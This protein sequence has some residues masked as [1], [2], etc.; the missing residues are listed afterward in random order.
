MS[1]Y[2]KQVSNAFISA[3]P[4]SGAHLAPNP[5]LGDV[6]KAAQASLAQITTLH[7][8]PTSVH[9]VRAVASAPF[10]VVWPQVEAYAPESRENAIAPKVLWFARAG[11]AA[12]ENPAAS[13]ID[14]MCISCNPKYY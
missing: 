1:L 9:E 7:P 6:A 5:K 3:L 13:T 2:S 10:L 14:L 12:N 8:G 11:V 4:L